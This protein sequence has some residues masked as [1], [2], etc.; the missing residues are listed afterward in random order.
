MYPV[1]EVEK[2]REKMEERGYRLTPQRTV[3]L[4]ILLDHPNHHLSADEIY[5]EVKSKHPEYGLAT[6]YRT[7]ELFRDL[8]IVHQMDF[9][10]GFSRYEYGHRDHHHHLVC[11][12]CGR[13]EEFHSDDLELVERKISETHQFEVVGHHLKL[14]GYC[15]RCR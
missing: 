12:K 1:A 10:D 5:T 3:I 2:V 8:E 14:Y 4:E 11:L 7:L 15:R 6:V 13:V 9:A